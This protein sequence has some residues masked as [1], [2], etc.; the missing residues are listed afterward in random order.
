VAPSE[1][2]I[3]EPSDVEQVSLEE[4]ELADL[5]SIITGR[6]AS[7]NATHRAAYLRGSPSID[8]RTQ[9]GKGQIHCPRNPAARHNDRRRCLVLARPVRPER[10]WRHEQP[11]GPTTWHFDTVDRDSFSQWKYDVAWWVQ[12]EQTPVVG[13]TDPLPKLLLREEMIIPAPIANSSVCSSCICELASCRNN[14][15][16]LCMVSVLL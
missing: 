5:H 15:S 12:F 16:S 13:Q 14:W 10:A 7:T 4:L 6:S 11:F 8:D 1:V 3:H 9:T 2:S